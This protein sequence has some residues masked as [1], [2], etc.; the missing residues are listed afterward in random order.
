VKEK[1]MRPGAV[2]LAS[3][4]VVCPSPL[5]GAKEK[6]E[7]DRIVRAYLAEV[8]VQIGKNPRGLGS[9]EAVMK[10]FHELGEKHLLKNKDILHKKAARD[11]LKLDLWKPGEKVKLKSIHESDKKLTKFVG[12]FQ[13]DSYGIPPFGRHTYATLWWE[14]PVAAKLLREMTFRMVLEEEEVEKRKFM[15]QFAVPRLY[16]QSADPEKPVLAFYDGKE[17]FVLRM[18]YI[19]VGIYALEKID[20]YEVQQGK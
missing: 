4:L 10:K 9:R 16:R 8:A 2:L 13:K 3:V 14:P 18:V 5:F 20:W 7:D 15:E 6:D 19:K 17:L 11:Y 1:P 12:I